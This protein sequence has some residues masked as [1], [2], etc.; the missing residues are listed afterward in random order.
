MSTCIRLI[1]PFVIALAVP[2][3]SSESDGPTQGN[4][5]VNDGSSDT[6]PAATQ[7]EEGGPCYP[8]GTCNA[9]LSCY[10]NLCVKVPE[11]GGMEGGDVAAPT[12]D[13]NAA[14]D[15]TDGATT[16]S[17]APT[18]DADASDGDTG[19]D[20]VSAIDA[21]VDVGPDAVACAWNMYP[22]DTVDHDNDGSSVAQGD[23]NDCDDH[24]RAGVGCP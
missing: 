15:V 12:S 3:C 19:A 13:A 16:D 4:A 22:D 7:G 23:C 18:G 6:T 2:A 11:A 8:N 17:S 10:S 9:G 20:A 1:A 14:S 5:I 21:P 24:V